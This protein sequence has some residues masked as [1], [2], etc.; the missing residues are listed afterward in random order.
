MVACAQNKLREQHH[1]CSCC[2]A[3]DKLGRMQVGAGVL[4]LPSAMS[5]L[6][7]PGG[8]I[9]LVLSCKSL[10]PCTQVLLL[11]Y[12]FIPPGLGGTERTTA[13]RACL[14]S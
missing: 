5:Y 8:I 12:L 14:I 2:P 4:G 10:Q 13:G 6:G 7:W 11:Q 9:V 3:R 1:K